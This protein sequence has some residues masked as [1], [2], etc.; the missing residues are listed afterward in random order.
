M[1]QHYSICWHSKKGGSQMR[2]GQEKIIQNAVK[3]NYRQPYIDMLSDETRTIE[4]LSLL[5]AILH[6]KQVT[7]I[8]RQ[9]IDIFLSFIH[10]LT[11]WQKQMA[12]N[13]IGFSNITFDKILEIVKKE[14]ERDTVKII[15][16]IQVW[17]N[18]QKFSYEEV[19]YLYDIDSENIYRVSNY[20]N[21][22][23]DYS[24]NECE[25]ILQL[26]AKLGS[27]NS[28]KTIC[29]YAKNDITYEVLKDNDF[30]YE[31]ICLQKAKEYLPETMSVILPITK[32][33]NSAYVYEPTI[34]EQLDNIFPYMN[35]GMTL[36][37]KGKPYWFSYSLS[38]TGISL[39]V[40]H[41]SFY[42]MEIYEDNKHNKDKRIKIPLENKGTEYLFMFDGGVYVKV[43]EKWI[44]ATIKNFA[45]EINTRN[46]EILS[47]AIKEYIDTCIMS[48]KYI[49]EDL[50]KYLYNNL[51]YNEIPPIAANE[52]NKYH[53][54][55]K[56][57][58]GH[59]KKADF[60]NWNKANLIWCYSLMKNMDKFTDESKKLLL[61]TKYENYDRAFNKHA[62]LL[63]RLQEST[64]W[65]D[66]E[67]KKRV[68]K[69]DVMNI[70]ADYFDIA[71]KLKVKPSLCFS[72]AKR[73]KEA[74]DRLSEQ[75]TAKHTQ[76]IKIHQKSKFNALRKML[77]EGFEWI[78]TRNRLVHEGCSMHHCVAT[79]D[80]KINK[81]NC[82]I[83]SAINPTDN[84]RY[85]I[86]FV[87]RNNKYTVRQIY[88]I[89]NSTCPQEFWDYV[90][91]LVND[92][93]AA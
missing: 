22:N 33:S 85:T 27:F 53:D 51:L 41:A 65:I 58:K 62:F 38:L 60:V 9:E 84:K 30:S 86:E 19:K 63:N 43:A 54:I 91:S 4:E 18:L 92:N 29:S 72:S 14:K 39:K 47:Q 76:V 77:P 7:D 80:T 23:G 8:N 48:K 1:A 82:A 3:N 69:G 10:D 16:I 37:L 31:K 87:V 59:Y 20:L 15:V 90:Q 66:K 34:I 75:Y 42:E 67:T 17:N 78:R 68:N 26:T 25:K 83:Y 24:F 74:H 81:D 44:P 13:I 70:I 64:Y 45:N 73:V 40:K 61:S 11:K 50:K 89:W 55:D 36:S 57:M 28:T 32:E 12:C 21:E 52:V 93:K 88:G 35:P 46:N 49:W 6:N 79:Y 5:Y 71:H 56:M 2:K